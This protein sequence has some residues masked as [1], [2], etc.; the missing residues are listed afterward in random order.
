MT[1]NFGNILPFPI[2]VPFLEQLLRLCIES[3]TFSLMRTETSATFIA[4]LTT[5][6]FCEGHESR[7]TKNRNYKEPCNQQKI[8]P[9]KFERG[10]M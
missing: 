10:V 9:C 8:E 3:S 6:A 5:R 4:L 1:C 7:V 2:F